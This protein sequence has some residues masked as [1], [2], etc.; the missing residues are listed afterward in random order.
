MIINL[1]N[2]NP[3]TI[4]DW[5]S[6]GSRIILKRASKPPTKANA[7]LTRNIRFFCNLES[8]IILLQIQLSELF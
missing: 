3:P 4:A 2:E 6:L 7:R 5:A 8:T 1:G